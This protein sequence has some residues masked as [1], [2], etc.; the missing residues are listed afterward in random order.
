MGLAAAGRTT[1]AAAG[2]TAAAAGAAKVSTIE[3]PRPLAHQRQV[4]KGKL[5]VCLYISLATGFTLKTLD[6]KDMPKICWSYKK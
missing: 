1:A 4:P 2:G 3:C 6:T 5:P